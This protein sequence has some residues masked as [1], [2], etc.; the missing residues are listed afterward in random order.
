MITIPLRILIIEDNPTD[1][2]LIKRQ[3]KKIVAKPQFSVVE[4]LAGF[5]E[6]LVNFAPDLVLSDY[7]LPSCDGFEILELKKSLAPDLEFVFLTGTMEDEELASHTVLAGASGFILKKD[8]DSLGEKL[9]PI[10]KKVVYDMIGNHKIQE[11]I[12]KNKI[13]VQQIYNYLDN[14]KEDNMEKKEVIRKFKEEIG[15]IEEEPGDDR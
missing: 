2:E 15:S 9:N 13:A 11:R 14:L 1:V 10:L 7:N 3:L 12:R 5:E 4:D 8:L 6:Q